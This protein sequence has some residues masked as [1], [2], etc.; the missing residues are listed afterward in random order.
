[1]KNLDLKVI[2]VENGLK[3]IN[4]IDIWVCSKLKVLYK[5]TIVSISKGLTNRQRIE[6]EKD[7]EKILSKTITIDRRGRIIF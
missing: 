7:P 6:L 5:N 2:G 4:G 1:M 3:K